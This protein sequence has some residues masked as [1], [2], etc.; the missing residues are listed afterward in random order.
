MSFVN[1]GLAQGLKNF[2]SCYE[3]R[4]DV[5]IDFEELCDLRLWQEWSGIFSIRKTY[6]TIRRSYVTSRN[7][8]FHINCIDTSAD[9]IFVRISHKPHIKVAWPTNAIYVKN[10]IMWKKIRLQFGD[11]PKFRFEFSR[12]DEFGSQLFY[13]PLLK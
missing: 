8:S 13:T 3:Y 10:G 5:W 6:I 12:S 9:D 1:V 4:S 11:V 7:F 2:Y